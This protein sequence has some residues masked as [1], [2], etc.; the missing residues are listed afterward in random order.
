MNNYQRELSAI[1]VLL[2]RAFKLEKPAETAPDSE[3]TRYAAEH[4]SLEEDIF[5]V[6][7]DQNGSQR[8]GHGI[9]VIYTVMAICRDHQSNYREQAANLLN[10]AEI[11]NRKINYLRDALLANVT[12]VSQKSLRFHL[13]EINSAVDVDELQEVQP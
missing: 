11:E 3:H 9:S 10:Y 8:L 13:H 6:L 2:E 7:T 4:N 5:Q 12:A 1:E